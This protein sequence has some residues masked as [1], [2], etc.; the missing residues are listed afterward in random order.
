MFFSPSI[1][2]FYSLAPVDAALSLGLSF[3]FLANV[4]PAKLRGVGFATVGAGL[5]CRFVA[6]FAE[7]G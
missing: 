5:V 6:R 4:V 7:R 3:T 2:S 1:L